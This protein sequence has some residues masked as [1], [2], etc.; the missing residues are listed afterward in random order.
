MS[1]KKK[2]VVL[3]A[4]VMFAAVVILTM[5]RCSAIHA[6]E[7]NSGE[8]NSTS[9]T[10]DLA[11][12][13]NLTDPKA[14]LPDSARSTIAS[15]NADTLDFIAL[16]E[17][18]KWTDSAQASTLSFSDNTWITTSGS[19]PQPTPTAFAITVLDVEVISDGGG[20]SQHAYTASATTA[21]GS[22]ILTVKRALD[23]NGAITWKIESSMFG[24]SKAAFYMVQGAS[25][26]TFQGDIDSLNSAI[27]GHAQ[28]LISRLKTYCANLYPT[29]RSASW[30]GETAADWAQG[31]VNLAVVLDNKAV[32]RIEII[33]NK[34]SQTFTFGTNKNAPVVP[35]TIDQ[36]VTSAQQQSPSDPTEDKESTN[37]A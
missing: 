25:A 29:A 15:Y 7:S 2:R 13:E 21:Q 9:E 24:S 26:L 35:A 19:N 36:S 32:S 33:Y 34:N 37:G 23:F 8:G 28:A 5:V 3:V 16:L 14:L 22:Y 12:E 30:T 31:T 27:D 10:Q 18:N 11:N 1:A 4:L 6:P 20:T 17:T